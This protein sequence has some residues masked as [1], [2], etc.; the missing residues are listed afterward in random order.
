MKTRSLFAA[1][2]ILVLCWNVLIP[3]RARADVY[4]GT[5]VD[6][7]TGEPLADAVLVVVWWTRAYIG[8]ERPRD[9]HQA[10]E[11]V[12]GVNGKFSMDASPAI[13]WNPLTYVESPPT[14]IIY[15]PGYR[16]LEGDSAASRGFRTLSDLLDALKAGTVVKLAKPKSRGE[17]M[18]YT[19]V[20]SLTGANVPMESVP[21]LTRLVNIQRKMAGLTSFFP[22][23]KT[24]E[25]LP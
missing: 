12:I 22:E 10:K 18:R 13:N 3:A 21:N 7:Q 17:T 9:F 8:F 2:L 16:P 4:Q 19:G 20:L 24:G 23:T 1:V 5:V 15:K 14:I 6:E 11:A 25:K